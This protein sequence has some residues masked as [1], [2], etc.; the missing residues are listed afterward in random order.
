LLARL[1]WQRLELGL[2]VVHGLEL[3]VLHA[4]PDPES[5]LRRAVTSCPRL[6]PL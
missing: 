4:A 3:V 5:N 2:G 1:P 6:P